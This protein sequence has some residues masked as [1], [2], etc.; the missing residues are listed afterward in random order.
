MIPPFA[1]AT[2]ISEFGSELVL[3][4]DWPV[5]QPEDLAPGECLVQIDYAGVCHSDLHI[6]NG[7]W[8]RDIGL[9]KVGGHEGIGHVV[10]IGANSGNPGV[11]IGDR[12]GLK[13]LASVCM[14]C[15]Q[16]FL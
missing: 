12:V 3:K 9:P 8:S 7:H 6:R 13:W 16:S 15:V 5:K 10:A 1:P 14:K 11:K 2:I 4:N